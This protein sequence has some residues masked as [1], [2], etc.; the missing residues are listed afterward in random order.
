MQ[1]SLLSGLFPV[2]TLFPKEPKGAE[3]RVAQC[4]HGFLSVFLTCL[5]GIRKFSNLGVCIFLTVSSQPEGELSTCV[6]GGME[7]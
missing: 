3:E 2:V 4:D 6:L 5:L 1:S 7:K